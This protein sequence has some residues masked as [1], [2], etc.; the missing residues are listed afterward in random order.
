VAGRV[1]LD[2]IGPIA[3]NRQSPAAKTFEAVA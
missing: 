1:V 2:F 3:G